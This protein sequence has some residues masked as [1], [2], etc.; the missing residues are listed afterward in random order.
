MDEVLLPRP[1]L[2]TAGQ[3]VLYSIDT[4]RAS[5]QS[6]GI[7]GISTALRIHGLM[8]INTFISGPRV[9][10]TLSPFDCSLSEC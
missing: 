6:L 1:D 8:I 9:L 10:C 3:I 2:C 7:F 4:T 5:L